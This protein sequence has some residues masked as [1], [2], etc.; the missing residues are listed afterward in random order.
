MDIEALFKKFISAD[1]LVKAFKFIKS[2]RILVKALSL[3]LTG[4]IAVVI[5]IVAVGITL[6]F[7]VE[8]SGKII[9]TVQN[10][11]VFENAK[12]IAAKNI[13]TEDAYDN[14]ETP[15][16]A[17]TVT[18]VDKLDSAAAVADAIIENTGDFVRATALSVNG[19]QVACVTGNDLSLLLE[20]RRTAFYIKGA[21]NTASFKDEVKTESGYFLKSEICDISE[22]ETI[23]NSL[24]VKTVSSVTTDITVPYATKEVKTNTQPCGYYE[25][26]TA[27]K[28]GLTRRTETVETLNGN[29]QSRTPVSE[30][31]VS[32]P[33]TKVITI[34]TAPV[35]L[36]AAEKANVTSAGFICPIEKGKF[37]ITSYY[38]D[39]RNHKGL[40]LGA[41]HGVAIFAAASGTV[42][43]AGYRN[44]Y[45]YSIVIDHG[46]GMQTKYAHAS[47][48][49]AGV[50]ERVSQGD[51]IATV[52]N[53]GYSTGNHLHFEVIVNDVRVNPAPYIG[54][55]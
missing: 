15:H 39:G 8:Y 1:F 36:S 48:L 10:T 55:N 7:D 12:S 20:A 37:V 28:N 31:T 3:C 21:Q 33:V 23:I 29:E 22:A 2:N 43:Y 35:K 38:G 45:G 44:D 25:V 30:Q 50:G 34:G 14:I 51:M 18:V 4:L 54:L 49:C 41:D 53:T 32:T 26:T 19:E 40:D 24:S 47:I 9:A 5:S 52:G 6:G 16:F 42:T 17:L 11:G 46:N 27:G 13:S